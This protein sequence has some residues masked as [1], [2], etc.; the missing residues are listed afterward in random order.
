MITPTRW[1]VPWGFATGFLRRCSAHTCVDLFAASRSEPTGVPQPIAGPGQ[2]GT[3]THTAQDRDRPSG[4]RDELSYPETEQVS[5]SA[6]SNEDADQRGSV[7]V[8]IMATP[9]SR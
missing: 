6:H 8:L 5:G 9:N 4:G 1:A 7:A 3:K 2:A